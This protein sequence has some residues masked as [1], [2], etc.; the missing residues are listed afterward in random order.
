MPFKLWV[1]YKMVVICKDKFDQDDKFMEYFQIFPFPLSDFQKYAIQAIVEGDHILVT[2][3]TGSG[4]TLPAEFAI[5]Y[6]VKLGKKVIYTS[7]IK[8]L[9]NQKFHEFTKKFP[10]ISFGILT[11]DI[12]YNP[13][14][15]VLIMTTEILRNTLLQK[16]IDNTNNTKTSALHFEMD[17][18]SELAAVIF[19]EVHYIN[20]HDRGK[21]WEETIMLLPS[22]VQLVMLSATIDKSEIFAKWI[23]D[24]KTTTLHHKKVYLA[25]T[26]YRV[27]PLKHYFYTTL[28][29][30][31][32][33]NI[34]DKEFLKYVNEFLHKP[35][36]VKDDSC[37]FNIDNYGKVKKLLTY[38]Q[39]N[40]CHVNPA[41]VLTEVT[42]YLNQNEMLPAICF[43]FS[44]KLVERYAKTIDFSLFESDSTIPSTIRYECEQ[45]LRKLPNFKEYIHLP[46]FQ[47]IIKLLEKGV[48]IH[49]SGIMPIFREMIELLF[50]KGYIK[51]LFATETF[52]VGIN[53]PTKTV[54]FT[55]FDK[56]NG[57]SMRLLYPHE[58]TQMAGRAG[59]RG[60]DT[61]GHVIHLNNMFDLPFTNEYENLLN[62]NPQTLQSKFHI[63]Y[64]L[65]MNFLRYNNNA[66]DFANKSMCNGEIVRQIREINVHISGLKEELESKTNHPE[67]DYVVNNTNTFETYLKLNEELKTA[68]QKNRKNIQKTLDDMTSS[69]LFDKQFKQYNELINLKHD[70]CAYEDRVYDLHNYFQDTFNNN[71]QFLH[72][73]NFVES[74]VTMITDNNIIDNNNHCSDVYTTPKIQVSEKGIISTYIQETHC[75]AFIDLLIKYNYFKS[76]NSYEIAALLSCFANIKVKDEIKIYNTSLL[77]SNQNLNDLL[78]DISTIYEHYITE[79]SKYGM[80]TTDSL[81]Y[82][83]ELVNPILNWCE[84]TDELTCKEIIASCEY[85]YEIF[86]GEFIKSILK[87]NNLV[88]ELKNIAEHNGNIELLHKLTQIP[89]LTLKFIAT[90]QS[91]YV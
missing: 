35:I 58:Y 49:H 80:Q 84:S 78:T 14:A 7:P 17:F 48:A 72:K 12:K 75:L 10:H 24:V 8:A 91:L 81:S 42:K 2:A 82:T 73:F 54:L 68:K 66:L 29:Q 59:R 31:P 71:I 47:M 1:L 60:L 25:P 28:P 9:S 61:I 57:S 6:L 46:E 74:D 70:I 51:L 44:R 45:I 5:E 34:K 67:Y 85:T 23:E 62:G 76:F 64:N 15:D 90:N 77:T 50:A 19:D 37:R 26:N 63:S 86:A 53:M 21:V 30:G 13:E 38:I 40:N 83:F 87:I 11:G 32:L 79:E 41:F 43:V 55:G 22:H 65:I 56:Y 88:N 18:Q 20:D 33:K 36:I 39:K 27:V 69:K 16:S 52:A 89:E 4:K 3:H